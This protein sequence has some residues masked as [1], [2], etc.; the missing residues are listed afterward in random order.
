M[1]NVALMVGLKHCF[2]SDT[3]KKVLT[4]CLQFQIQNTWLL[5]KS[6]KNLHRDII[7]KQ[8]YFLTIKYEYLI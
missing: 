3:L 5:K 1:A 2:M 7:I 8:E 4:D 6:D